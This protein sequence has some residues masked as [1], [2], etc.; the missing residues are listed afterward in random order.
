M[1]QRLSVWV[2]RADDDSSMRPSRVVQA[3][4]I[5]TILSQ[6]DSAGGR[7]VIE[8]GIIANPLT[9]STCLLGCEYVMA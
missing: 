4:K 9:S 7:G 3:N 5:F 6:Q 8:H 1:G 2:V